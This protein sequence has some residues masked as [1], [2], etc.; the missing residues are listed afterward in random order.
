M[1]IKMKQTH[2]GSD[3]DEN[4]VTVGP[5]IYEA[6]KEYE[7]GPALCEAFCIHMKAAELVEQVGFKD[8]DNDDDPDLN[9]GNT[10]IASPENKDLGGP[11]KI[12]VDLST[13]SESE[14]IAKLLDSNV[15]LSPK[16]LKKMSKADLIKMIEEK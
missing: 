11:P 9:K 6:G 1:R 5:N 8:D 10:L 4:G 3:V 16:K 15:T 7:V 13:L 14:L 2:S 12:K